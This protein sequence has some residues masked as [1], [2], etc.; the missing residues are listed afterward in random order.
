MWSGTRNGKKIPDRMVGERY[1]LNDEANNENYDGQYSAYDEYDILDF[2]PVE[3]H[4]LF[5]FNVLHHPVNVCC[6]W[7]RLGTGTVLK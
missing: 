3:F 5:L 6:R 7:F 4:L 2:C 1:L